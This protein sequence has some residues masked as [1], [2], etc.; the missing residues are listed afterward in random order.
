MDLT[1]QIF[2][3]GI[4][5]GALYGLVAVGYSLVYGLLRFI[6]FA[7]AASIAIGAYVFLV[8]HIW[9]EL[10]SIIAVCISLPIAG[11]FGILVNLIAYYPFRQSSLLYPLLTGFALSIIVENTLAL[12]FGPAPFRV[13]QDISGSSVQLFQRYFFPTI[14]I[15]MLLAA[16]IAGISIHVGMTRTAYGRAIRATAENM[17]LA[18]IRGVRTE[19]MISIVFFL[20]SSLAGLAGILI[21]YDSQLSPQIG[22]LPS[23]KGFVAAL[24]GGL[25]NF[26]GALIAALF[27]GLFENLMIIYLPSVYKD[28]SALAVLIIF[29]AFR[30]H[31][32]F[33]SVTQRY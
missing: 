18:K 6:N 15:Y 19:I 32:L 10:P 8:L 24:V 16:M 7:H 33:P 28:A 11:V 5:A 27:L 21:A 31:G 23:L 25:G 22:T 2:L 13:T 29:L 26:T 3:N 20:S 14:N 17:E 30:P 1:I 12:I 9:L 4:A